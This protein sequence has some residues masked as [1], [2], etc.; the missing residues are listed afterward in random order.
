MRIISG[1]LKGRSI[2]A[3]ANLPV[4][5]TTDF[6]KESLFNI[7][8]NHIDYDGLT[9]LDLF[10]GTGNISYEFASRGVEAIT[11]V[12]DN[13]KCTSFVKETAEKFGLANIKVVKYDAFQFLKSTPF[14]FDII[15][16]DPPY[17]MEKIESVAEIIFEKKLLNIGGWLII[18]HSDKTK[19]SALPFFYESRTYGKVNFSIF[20]NDDKE[21]K[22]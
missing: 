11:A 2:V 3:T 13:F 22:K 9:V 5:P 14:T 6:A 18:E 15:F 7:L 17:E 19:L 21:G 10:C 12:D 16:A 4:R 1:K 8:N 20:K